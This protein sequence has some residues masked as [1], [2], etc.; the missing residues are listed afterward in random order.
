MRTP[1]QIPNFL[2]PDESVTGIGA[3]RIL[4]IYELVDQFATE[5]QIDHEIAFA[6]L[7]A[8]FSHSIGGAFEIDRVR[9]GRSPM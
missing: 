5:F 9:C 7:L 1:I 2:A 3:F 4:G 6:S 8:G